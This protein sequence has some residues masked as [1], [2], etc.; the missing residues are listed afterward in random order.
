M[1][2]IAIAVAAVLLL[3]G[4]LWLW[5]IGPSPRRDIAPFNSFLYAH[6][7][8]HTDDS[9]IPENS[10]AAFRRAAELGV[11]VELD[12][13]FSADR[14]VVVFHDNTLTRMCG[15]NQRVD[16]LTYEELKALPLLGS[17]EGIPLL[18]EV[19]EVL[20]GAP[21][22]CEF[23]SRPSFTDTSLCEAAWDI[24]KDYKGPV[25]IESFN[26]MMVGW[27]KKHQPTVVR[28]VLSCVFEPDNKEVSPF[29][30]KLLTNLLTNFLARPDFIAY[31]HTDT[32]A[33][34]LRLCKRLFRAPTI[35]WTIRSQKEQNAALDNGFATVIFEGYLPPK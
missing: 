18:K 23:K 28:G 6:R 29:V 11:A 16:S 12:V 33:T 9:R 22:L 7:G 13:Q 34:A 14:Q 27:F 17:D 20:D 3:G 2:Y 26:P 30:G 5:L 32:K 10:L 19:L 8:L 21:V 1:L 15:V 4:A 24:L 25:C 35:A 31:R